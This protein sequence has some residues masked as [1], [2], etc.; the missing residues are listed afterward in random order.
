MKRVIYV[1]LAVLALAYLYASVKTEQLL[2]Q[3]SGR[4]IR[5]G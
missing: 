2:D 4:P 5:A 1:A 3:D